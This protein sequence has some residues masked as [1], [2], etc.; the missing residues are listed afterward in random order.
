[1]I[2]YLISQTKHADNLLPIMKNRRFS[3]Q[4]II[5]PSGTMIPHSLFMQRKL[6]LIKKLI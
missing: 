3:S 5:D 1:M 2:D 6:F 4:D